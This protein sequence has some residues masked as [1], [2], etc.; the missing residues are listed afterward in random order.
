MVPT[1]KNSGNWMETRHMRSARRRPPRYTSE[2]YPHQ[3][4]IH[5]ASDA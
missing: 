5:Y 4:P 3:K 2:A 1:A